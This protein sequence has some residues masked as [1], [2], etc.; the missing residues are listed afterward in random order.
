M[1][2]KGA[3]RAFGPGNPELPAIYR[4]IGQPVIIPGDM[5]R[6][7]YLL[8]GT[9]RA[10]EETFASTCHGAGRLMSRTEA[11]R[12]EERKTLLQDLAAKGIKVMAAGRGTL[13]EEAPYAY[14]NVNEVVD[15]VHN[16]GIAKKVCRMRPIGVIKG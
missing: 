1:H 9:K 16:A 12:R 10:E 2:R 6:N 4:N 8:V 7:S 15:V 5:G 13:A 14:K 11:M 3:T